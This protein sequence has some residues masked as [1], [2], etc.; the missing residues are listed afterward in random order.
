M[1]TRRRVLLSLINDGEESV[2]SLIT[3]TID[4]IEYQAEEGMTWGEWVNSEYNVDGYLNYN[5]VITNSSVSRNIT[6]RGGASVFS[7]E[8]IRFTTY[9]S[10]TFK[11][12]SGGVD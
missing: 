7:N 6:G 4:G 1:A 5:T 8:V 2:G 9:T 12:D 10:T 11:P 3:F